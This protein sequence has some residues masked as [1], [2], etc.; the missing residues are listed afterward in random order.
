MSSVLPESEEPTREIAVD[1]EHRVGSSL[2]R[3][4]GQELGN[5]DFPVP[6][7]FGCYNLGSI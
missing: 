7:R 4:P 5:S 2:L 6:H 3:V 1:D